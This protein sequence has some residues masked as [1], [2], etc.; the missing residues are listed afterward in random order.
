MSEAKT[1][2]VT[3]GSGFIGASTCL[4][5]VEEDYNVVNIDR[6]KRELPGV[7]QYPFELDNHQVRGLIKLLQPD[8]NTWRL[9]TW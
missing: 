8:A 3:G 5:L 2:L 1:V 6:R 9:V 7:T 4:R